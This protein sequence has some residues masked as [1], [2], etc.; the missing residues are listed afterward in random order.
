MLMTPTAEHRQMLLTD[1]RARAQR[2]RGEV[3]GKLGDAAVDAQAGRGGIDSGELSFAAAESVLDLAEASRDLREL[4]AIDRAMT[5][6]E[7]GRY[8]RCEQCGSKI[9]AARLAAQP[10]ALR[11]LDCQNRDE[12][13]TGVQPARL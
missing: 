2:L 1:L 12:R 10:L 5:A 9:D 4:D 3:A 8:G 11:C 7:T 13:R 6:I